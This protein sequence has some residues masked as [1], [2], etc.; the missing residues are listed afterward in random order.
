MDSIW[1]MGNLHAAESYS[2]YGGAGGGCGGG[3]GGAVVMW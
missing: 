1:C 3:E 2:G